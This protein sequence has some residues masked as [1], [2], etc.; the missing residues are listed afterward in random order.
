MAYVALYRKYRSQ[1]FGELM[2]QEAV[3]TTLQNAIRS[4]L[5]AHA[6]LFYG[7]RGCGKTSTARLLARALNCEAQ[8]G[9][10]PEPCGVCRL[11]VSIRDGHCMDVVEMDAASETGIDDVR[12][13]IIENVQYA[14]GEARYKVYIIDEVHDLSAKAFDA[15]LKTLEEPP[16]HVKFILATTEYHKVPITIRSRCQQFQFKRGTLNDLAAA[17]QK[18][19][20]AENYTAEPEAVQAI[21]R[22]AEGSWRDAL[23]LLEQVLAYSDSH[24]TAATVQRALGTVGQ[25]TLA[26]VTDILARGCWDETLTIAGE[27]IDSGKDARQLLTAL[28]GHLRDLM[29]ISAGAKQAAAQELGPERLALLTPQAVLFDPPTLL[30]MMS[31]LA[32]AER[33]I[34][35]TNQHRW[36]LESTLLRLLTAH[37]GVGL[38]AALDQ[39]VARPVRPTTQRPLEAPL[40]A[41]PALVPKPGPPAANHLYIDRA[42]VEPEAMDEIPVRPETPAAPPPQPP[43]QSYAVP[44][45]PITSAQQAEAPSDARFAED[46]TLEVLQRAWTRILKNM[47]KSSPQGHSFLKDAEVVDLDGR[48]IVLAFQSSFA[49]ERIQNNEKG[50]VRVEQIINTTL[51]TEGYRIRC[52][53]A[54][55]G[56]QNGSTAGLPPTPAPSGPAT[57]ATLIDAPITAPSAPKSIADFQMPV[58]AAVTTEPAPARNS[59]AGS[60]VS[61]PTAT[62][63]V[64]AAPP[65]AAAETGLL[66]DALDVFQ[67]E[68]VSAEPL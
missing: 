59:A 48:F 6:Y 9:P 67:G 34:R 18:V 44:P 8:D 35:F 14:P 58:P 54:D 15:L 63:P 22:A 52:I 66:K 12:E 10:N 24:V 46:M 64:K 53:L 56:G 11:C 65:P 50:R 32:G 36:L 28:Q 19:V 55:G 13:K 42:V 25:E 29:L 17:V 47:E 4:G 62:P 45:T 20:T 43:A 57:T 3:T 60:A 27:L 68:I 33:E 31:V 49:R 39:A 37:Q 41:S 7:A 38:P 21:A 1:S 26:R 2:G 61:T 30:A 51:N 5:I 40:A 16:A 23:S